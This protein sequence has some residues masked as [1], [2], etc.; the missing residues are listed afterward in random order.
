MRAH[1]TVINRFNPQPPPRIPFLPR[2]IFLANK[3]PLSELTFLSHSDMDDQSGSSRLRVLFEAALRDYEKQTGTAL[4]NHPLA[5]QLQACDSVD[6]ITAV[7]RE[8]TKTFSEFRD[9]DKVMKPLRKAVSVLYKL[10]AAASFGQDI[11]L[12]RP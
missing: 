5:E 1:D 6:S 2:K 11:G 12:V 9:N 8:Q 4:V 7:L 10:S 3:F